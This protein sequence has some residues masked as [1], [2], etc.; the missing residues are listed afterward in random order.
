MGNELDVYEFSEHKW[1]NYRG[2]LFDVDI[3]YPYY[4]ATVILALGIVLT[5]FWKKPIN[6]Y[7]TKLKARTTEL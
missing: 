4:F 2:M 7:S 6:D 5:M 3:N 1:A